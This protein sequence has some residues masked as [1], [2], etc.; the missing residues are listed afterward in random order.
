MSI[1]I[2]EGA[3]IKSG[4]TMEIYEELF[5]RYPALNCVRSSVLAAYN[6]L[7]NSFKNEGKLL[8]C[9][10]GG[11]AADAEHIVGELMKGFL[12]RREL[13][14]AKRD[15]INSVFSEY[16][17]N[18]AGFLQGALPAISLAGE[19]ALSTAY[20]NDVHPEM[21]FAQQTFAY[22]KNNDVFLGIST[23]GNSKNVVNAAL[24][25]K[26]IGLKTIALTGPMNSSLSR[27]CDITINVPGKNTPEVQEHHL[28]VYHALCA[29][30]EEELF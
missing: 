23:S 13:T 16:M 30:L 28:P 25:A 3:G 15:V 12:K 9:G 26:A 7:F 8:V 17:E 10:N 2:A 6:A 4:K 29:M 21:I 19:R 27:I 14:S 24:T 5:D 1:D 11:S 20:L 22:G 18:A